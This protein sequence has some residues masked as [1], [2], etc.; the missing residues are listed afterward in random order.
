MFRDP[1]ST[2]TVSI[3]GFSVVEASTPDELQEFE[4]AAAIGFESPTTTQAYIDALLD[5][6]G[7]HFYLGR[8]RGEIVTG[9]ASFNNGTSLGIYSLFTF[10]EARRR[11]YGE[12]VVRAA[13]SGVTDLP[14]VTEA[15]NMSFNL[16]GRLGL[17]TVGKRTIWIHPGN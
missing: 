8:S 6:A 17:Q 9:V 14:V 7:Y 3:D 4:A 11:G 5:H 2:G 12:A 13:M 16:F 15:S 10:P 1:G